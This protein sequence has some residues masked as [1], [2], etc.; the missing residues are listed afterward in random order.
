[1]LY[2]KS[3]TSSR[4]LKSIVSKQK[5]LAGLARMNG[6]TGKLLADTVLDNWIDRK[7]STI[8]IRPNLWEWFLPVLLFRKLVTWTWDFRCIN[9]TSKI[10]VYSYTT[11]NHHCSQL[12][13]NEGSHRFRAI[14][15]QT[16]LFT[17]RSDVQLACETAHSGKTMQNV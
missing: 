14:P 1:M 9:A 2:L 5:Q 6:Q 8:R 11:Q 12:Y 15:G 4:S 17:S 7:V 3:I 16:V 13:Y 10:S